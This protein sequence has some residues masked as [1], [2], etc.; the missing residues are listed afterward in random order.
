MKQLSNNPS[1]YPDLSTY[2]DRFRKE[3]IWV[4]YLSIQIFLN[5]A[6]R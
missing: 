4:K 1:D 5:H 6:L 2:G 3:D